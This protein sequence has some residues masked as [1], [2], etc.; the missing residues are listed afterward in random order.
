M[1]VHMADVGRRRFADG[2]RV[3]R[4]E[5]E[6][7]ARLAGL[8]FD[9]VGDGEVLDLGSDLLRPEIGKDAALGDEIRVSTLLDES[10]FAEDVDDVGLDDR[11]QP[12][13]DGQRL[14][15][16][17]ARGSRKNAPCGPC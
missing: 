16:Q 12:M 3:G 13:G 7:L 17:I 15:R 1:A 5:R 4:G 14:Q 11:R 2:R 10:A 8:G 9:L 6:R